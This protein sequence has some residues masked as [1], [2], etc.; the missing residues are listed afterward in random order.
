MGIHHIIAVF[1]N[2]LFHFGTEQTDSPACEITVIS[3]SKLKWSPESKLI[4][5]PGKVLPQNWISR[6]KK[7]IYENW[8]RQQSRRYCDKAH[9]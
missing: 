2:N 7:K 5:L 8:K 9:L 3:Q 4:I 1:Q 6:A